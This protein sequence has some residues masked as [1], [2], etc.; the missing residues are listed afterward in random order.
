MESS[1]AVSTANDDRWGADVS[2]ALARMGTSLVA[3]SVLLWQR[4][5]GHDCFQVVR[6]WD[7]ADR[8]TD[9]IPIGWRAPIEGTIFEE[10]VQQSGHSPTLFEGP[11]VA[12]LTGRPGDYVVAALISG[13]DN[14][15]VSLVFAGPPTMPDRVMA[16]TAQFCDLA[17]QIWRRV[18]AERMLQSRLDMKRVLAE[19]AAR[20]ADADAEAAEET[21]GWA[22][23]RL[24]AQ[25]NCIV[26]TIWDDGDDS[27]V[28][29]R[30][31]WVNPETADP[32]DYP[33][34]TIPFDHPISI[35]VRALDRA[36]LISFSRHFDSDVPRQDQSIVAASLNDSGKVVG[37]VTF[38]FDSRLPDE[39]D[40]EFWYSTAEGF[41][42]LIG[43][44][45]RRARA[46]LAEKRSR[47]LERVINEI[48]EMFVEAPSYEFDEVVET[49]MRKLGVLVEA[50]S[51]AY[52][53]IDPVTGE[54]ELMASWSEDPERPPPS[55][56]EFPCTM[57]AGL[58]V[59]CD[60]LSAPVEVGGA[61]VG[62][63]VFDADVSAEVEELLSALAALLSQFRR[64]VD[65]ELGLAARH[66]A[67]AVLRDVAAEL[68][69]TEDAMDRALDRLLDGTGALHLSLWREA[70]GT[71]SAPMR[72]TRMDCMARS[73]GASGRS[74]AYLPVSMVQNF[75]EPGE[76][77][78][79]ELDFVPKWLESVV[80]AG[81]EPT[82]RCVSIAVTQI[83]SNERVALF[84][85][86]DGSQAT[87]E[88]QRRMLLWATVMLA[89]HQ[90]RVAAEQTFAAAFE[91]APTALTIRDA[92]G[93]LIA[94][95]DAYVTFTGR[96]REDL[97]GGAVDDLL[98]VKHWKGI[99]V[100]GADPPA[101]LPYSRPDGSVVWGR[102]QF[103]KI[104]LVGRTESLLLSHIEDVTASR[105]AGRLMLH[106]ATHDSLTDLQN[107]DGFFESLGSDKMTLGC[108]VLVIDLD[109]FGAINDSL[110][111]H[112][113]DKALITASD[114]MRL[115]LRPGDRICRLGGD[116]F[117]I[118]LG[119]GVSEHE[120]SAVASRLLQ[121]MQ[122]P[123]NLES[124]EVLVTLSIGAAMGSPSSTISELVRFAD[125]AMYRA[126]HTGR[127]RFV[128]FD[129]QLR[130]ELSVHLNT[131]IELRTALRRGQFEVHY[132]PEV[133][134]ET[135]RIL[136]TEAL[137]RWN[138]PE[139][140]LLS[141]G[142]FVEIAE[143][144]GLIV[145]LGRW[146]L[147]EATK[148]AAEWRLAGFDIVMRVNLSVRQLR[149]VV[150]NEIREALLSAGLRP[151]HL[152]LEVTETAIM[153]DV[154]DSIR[155]LHQINAMGVML[156]ID[157]FG[158]GYSSLAYL[159][160]FPVDIL[161]IDKVFVD[162][163]GI[164]A[165]DTGIVDTVIRLGRALD[166]QV[167]AE[168]IENSRQIDDLRSMGCERGQGFYLARPAPAADI[169]RLLEMKA[170]R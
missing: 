69:R 158:T 111:H 167:V 1:R 110:G 7:D 57:K 143:D 100:V 49:A 24:A 84:V 3:R 4:D 53:S 39:S 108:A 165:K 130:R 87:D 162:G 63:V 97:I 141:A 5:R 137:V 151:D 62:A 156:A 93:L 82:P 113:G 6:A 99:D 43:Q 125:A 101:E 135:G 64:R 152:C 22:L 29:R 14:A 47:K 2:A 105:L 98:V 109:R 11:P 8:S 134:L 169:A 136:G 117:A 131:E 76:V 31:V 81:L 119:G 155:L 80:G 140:G 106:R 129:D 145:E 19:V 55:R 104:K 70:V 168:G 154:E 83:A 12:A 56:V 45:R 34:D 37:A 121:L 15:A 66:L 153:R 77:A 142:E 61:T 92:D 71:D 26:A 38:A 60:L 116:E 44:L 133:D 89:E 40:L 107:R 16:A 75:P 132:Q 161:K 41:A 124:H 73:G 54:S 112:V 36:D 20:F 94:C 160:R 159:K 48:A 21:V 120:V 72:R 32:G 91:S 52:Y 13:R 27:M 148:Q 163:V 74:H 122:E 147:G 23:D 170:R 50:G 17:G 166:L 118:H 68:I 127:D 149:P 88:V 9:G 35:A 139:R 51:V 79:Y 90:A 30:H 78:D 67:D 115:A 65:A 146:V 96:P 150:V 59:D 123:M 85:L 144:A 25:F 10:L 42:A 102:V 103:N 126:K 114:R 95:N 58:C 86:S 18:S 128:M 46:E 28:H 157:D 33:V 164:N 138:H